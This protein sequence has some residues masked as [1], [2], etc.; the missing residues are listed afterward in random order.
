MRT[1][2]W[3]FRPAT[4]KIEHVASAV[5]TLKDGKVS[6]QHG[7]YDTHAFLKQLGAISG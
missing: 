7:F 4:I 2:I 6:E 3:G 1:N 5:V